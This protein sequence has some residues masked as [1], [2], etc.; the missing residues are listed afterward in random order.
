MWVGKGRREKQYGDGDEEGGEEEHGMGMKR[1]GRMGMRRR[2]GRS[3]DG[4]MG[5]D[6]VGRKENRN[7][8][9]C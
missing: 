5:L 3:K 8:S 1:M 6:D 7:M 9:A 4:R 2:G